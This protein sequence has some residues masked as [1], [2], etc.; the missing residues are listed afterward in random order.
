MMSNHP[1]FLNV[2]TLTSQIIPT[3]S[4]PT[5]NAEMTN[6]LELHTSALH[7]SKDTE[8]LLVRLLQKVQFKSCLLIC[9]WRCGEL[10]T[11][12]WASKQLGKEGCW[13]EWG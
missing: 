2:D 11:C 7:G 1:I 6:P 10:V 8:T 3:P 9:R 13:G 4:P 12:L 5:D